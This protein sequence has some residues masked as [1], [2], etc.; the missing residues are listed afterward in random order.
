MVNFFFVF[1]ITASWNQFD[2][3]AYVYGDK[4]K[5]FRSWGSSSED[6]TVEYRTKALLCFL[7]KWS[8]FLIDETTENMDA[9][10]ALL[11]L[12]NVVNCLHNVWIEEHGRHQ[13][14]QPLNFEVQ[15][16]NCLHSTLIPSNKK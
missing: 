6:N 5:F 3:V 2:G 12:D 1:Q 11:K 10:S 15:K 7:P 4:D 9:T 8:G 14:R 16:V 13:Q